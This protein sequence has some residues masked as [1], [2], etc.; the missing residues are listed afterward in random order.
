MKMYRHAICNEA[1]VKNESVK[2]HY[3]DD[4]LKTTGAGLSTRKTVYCTTFF[5]KYI[6]Y[7]YTPSVTQYK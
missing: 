5:F 6:P 3:I 4:R 1:Q 7:Y 2:S